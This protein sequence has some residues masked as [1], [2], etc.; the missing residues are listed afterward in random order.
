MECSINKVAYKIQLL[1][2]GKNEIAVNPHLQ[3]TTHHTARTTINY[4]LVEN[5]VSGATPYDIISMGKHFQ[6]IFHIL[7]TEIKSVLT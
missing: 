3:G 5:G 4:K 2:W 6:Q 1:E 7:Y